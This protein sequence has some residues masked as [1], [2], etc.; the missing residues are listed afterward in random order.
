M[1]AM[2][3]IVVGDVITKIEQNRSERR[4]NK[5]VVGSQ[6][7]F[8]DTNVDSGKVSGWLIA[9]QLEVVGDARFRE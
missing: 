2:V 3:A 5:R 8:A 1:I 9:L 7:Y 6:N 4:G